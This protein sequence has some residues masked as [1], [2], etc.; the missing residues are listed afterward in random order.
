MT[1][2]IALKVKGSLFAWNLGP[3]SFEMFSDFIGSNRKEVGGK[4]ASLMMSTFFVLILFKND[5]IA[6]QV[7]VKLKF[8]SRL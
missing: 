3:P 4:E 5:I 7:C 8:L 6:E 2:K 1:L